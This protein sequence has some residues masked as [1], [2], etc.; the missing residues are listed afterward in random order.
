MP[1]SDPLA[2]KDKEIKLLQIEITELKK[3]KKRKRILN[4]L[5]FRTPG[6]SE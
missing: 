4:P 3:E 1:N 5:N 6:I 2:E